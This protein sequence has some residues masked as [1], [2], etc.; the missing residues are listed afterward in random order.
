MYVNYSTDL[1]LLLRNPVATVFMESDAY[2]GGGGQMGHALPPDFWGKYLKPN[3]S[4][5]R[6]EKKNTT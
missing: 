4:K 3:I 6:K 2:L 5:E 1:R